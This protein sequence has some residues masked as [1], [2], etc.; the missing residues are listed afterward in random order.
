[1]LQ[2]FCSFSYCGPPIWTY[3]P[4]IS[5]TAQ[6]FSLQK[7]S[8]KL[9]SKPASSFPMSP[10]APPPPPPPPPLPIACLCVTVQSTHSLPALQGSRLDR[11]HKE[12]GQLHQ[13][14]A[15]QPATLKPQHT[16]TI[17]QNKLLSCRTE[18]TTHPH[19][20]SKQSHCQAALKPQHTHTILQNKV[21]ILPHWNQN[22]STTCFK[23]SSLSC[24]T[25]TTTHWHYTSKQ[26]HCPA[27]LKP[28][29]T[30]TILQNKVIVLLYWNHNTLTLYFKTRSLSCCTETTT[31]WHY[32]SKQGHCPAV[33]KPQ[34][35]H[36]ILQNKVTVPLHWNHNGN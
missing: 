18:T 23:T 3:F 15:R 10:S 16:H 36:T 13:T 28:Q 1:M 22:I 11:V 27:V 14:G 31:H 5:G 34:H 7:Q 25:E 8:W 26:G 9:V 17:L 32:T 4:L 6:L 24:C 35:T 29:H 20:T 2:S 19:H 21:N 12:L 30:D 33:L